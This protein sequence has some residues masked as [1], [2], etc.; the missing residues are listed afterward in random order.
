MLDALTRCTEARD[1]HAVALARKHTR[2][3][4]EADV[5]CFQLQTEGPVNR[6]EFQRVT[7]G[8]CDS[9]CFG[10]RSPPF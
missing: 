2:A 4:A 6:A 8:T 9:I 3:G 1:K 7:V 10:A 5:A